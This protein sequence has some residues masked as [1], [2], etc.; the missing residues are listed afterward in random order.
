MAME[1]HIRDLRYFLAVAE[2]LHFTRAAERL[3]VSQPAL[4]K[5]IGHLERALRVRLFERDRRRVTLTAAGQEL[6]KHARALIQQWDEAQRRVAE[7]AAREAAVLRVGLSTSVGRGILGVARDRFAQRWPH[8]RLDLRQV[9]WDDPTAGLADR[10]SDVALVWLPLPAAGALSWRVLAV[11]PRWVALPA[12]HRLAR[13]RR[14]DIADLLGEPF[15]ALPEAAGPLRDH[16][17]ATDARGGAR[18]TIAAEVTNAGEAF[19]MVSSGVGVALLAAGNAALYQ[20]PG[21]VTRP[22][23]GVGPSQLAVA[24][25]A[26]DRRAAVR[27]FVE[28]CSLAARPRAGGHPAG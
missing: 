16:W 18:P 21:V 5:Q 8:W 25:R 11:E 12:G 1:V 13:R 26:A 28:A 4:S 9:D 19:E 14:V 2:E 6:R 20:R 17:L 3:F 10:S 24:W 7:A 15:L 27:D 23:Q 22:V